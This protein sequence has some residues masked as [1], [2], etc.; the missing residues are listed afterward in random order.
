MRLASIFFSTKT[1]RRRRK[2][3]R[4]MKRYRGV[5][6][7]WPPQAMGFECDSFITRPRWVTRQATGG[8]V[9]SPDIGP[10]SIPA[11]LSLGRST[12]RRPGET[13]SQAMN[14]LTE[15]EDL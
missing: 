11:R 5:P 2:L 4:D 7:C 13:W 6:Y 12:T 15:G 1:A 10:D 3:I 14:R 9:R 8:H